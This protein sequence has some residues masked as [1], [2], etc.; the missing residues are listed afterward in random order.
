MKGKWENPSISA[1]IPSFQNILNWDSCLVKKEPIKPS[2][3][4]S[5]RCFLED[6]TLASVA[7]HAD[8]KMKYIF[9]IKNIRTQV[10][11]A[12]GP[13]VGHGNMSIIAHSL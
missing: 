7:S 10:S 4:I 3:W 12:S 8:E 6:S 13:S 1:T 11:F 2:S 5:Y 9:S